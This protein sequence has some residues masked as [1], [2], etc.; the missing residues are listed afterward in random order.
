MYVLLYDFAPSILGFMELMRGL[1]VEDDVIMHWLSGILIFAEAEQ[2][3]FP[4]L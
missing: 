3:V 2:T 4:N 1:L